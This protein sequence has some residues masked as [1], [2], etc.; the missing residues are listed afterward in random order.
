MLHFILGLYRGYNGIMENEMET[1]I[2]KQ[3]LAAV[4]LGDPQKQR[5][6]WLPRP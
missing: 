5:V 6:E 2:V 3:Y 1:I 4:P